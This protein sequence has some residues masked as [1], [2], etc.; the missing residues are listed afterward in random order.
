M[1][2]T[3]KNTG[4]FIADTSK[5]PMEGSI[6]SQEQVRKCAS[7]MIL[8]ASGWRKVF[9]ISGD[10]EDKSENLSIEDKYLAGFIALSLAK[11]LNCFD[12][13]KKI[14]H[15]PITVL[16]AMD[17]RPTGPSIANVITRIF[18]SLD[19]KVKSLFIAAAPEIMAYSTLKKDSISSF[20]YISA[21]HNPI[22][23]NGIKFGYNGGVY[24]SA[25]IAPMIN[26]FEKFSSNKKYLQIVKDLVDNTDIK[27]Y[28]QVLNNIDNEKKLSLELYR[29]FCLEIA[30]K[31]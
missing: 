10:E 7:N 29:A 14:N 8:S 16:L 12:G 2:Y 25:K 18:I 30:S 9:A 15:E 1:I 27:K 13:I 26:D 24:T 20:L 5:N 4:F 28:E 3:G 11:H 23:H 31:G 6:P 19:I 17:A 22:G 21:S